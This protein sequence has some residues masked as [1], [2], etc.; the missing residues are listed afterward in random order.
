MRRHIRRRGHKHDRQGA[1]ACPNHLDHG[2]VVD[3]RHRCP[4]HVHHRQTCLDLRVLRR[5]RGRAYHIHPHRVVFTDKLDA[6]RSRLRERNGHLVR[7]S[8]AWHKLQSHRAAASLEQLEAVIVALARNVSRTDSLQ[9][10][11]AFKLG[12]P[13]SLSARIDSEHFDRPCLL[14]WCEFEPKWAPFGERNAD[15][16]LR[17]CE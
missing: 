6:Q 5:L 3:A 2:V 7:D 9:D 15:L 12:V 17:R 14:V 4:R 11:P 13:L 1:A 16:P 10:K 8:A